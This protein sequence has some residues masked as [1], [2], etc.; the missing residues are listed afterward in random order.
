MS[1]PFDQALYDRLDAEADN[2]API[3]E[4]MPKVH[5]RHIFTEWYDGWD[6]C[7]EVAARISTERKPVIDEDLASIFADAIEASHTRNPARPDGQ[8]I[9]S[10]IRAVRAAIESAK[11]TTND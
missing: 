10:G 7:A 5:R 3:S 9:I 4:N 11:E 8:H 1:E 2:H 6:A